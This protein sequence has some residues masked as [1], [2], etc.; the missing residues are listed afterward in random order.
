M[1]GTAFRCMTRLPDYTQVGRKLFRTHHDPKS[2]LE[3][4]MGVY[5][6]GNNLVDVMQRAMNERW[7]GHSNTSIVLFPSV[8]W[9]DLLSACHPQSCL[10]VHR[11]PPKKVY[12][13]SPSKDFMSK[14]AQEWGDDTQ[15]GCQ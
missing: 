2:H 8:K 1:G 7:N 11:F 3:R 5:K 14:K 9:I 10:C 12:T 4:S 15:L 13:L 6:C